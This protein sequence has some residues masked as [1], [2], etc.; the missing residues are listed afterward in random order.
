[1]KLNKRHTTAILKEGKSAE[2]VTEKGKMQTWKSETR[3][4]Q[5]SKPVADEAKCGS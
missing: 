4:G 1:M 3:R 5:K 2:Y